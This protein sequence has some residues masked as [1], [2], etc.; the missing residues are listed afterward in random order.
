MREDDQQFL[1]ASWE[2]WMDARNFDSKGFNIV[3]SVIC[4]NSIAFLKGLSFLGNRLPSVVD[5]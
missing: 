1:S 5:I 2:P 3:L 4:D